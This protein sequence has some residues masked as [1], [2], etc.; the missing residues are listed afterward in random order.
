MELTCAGS[1]FTAVTLEGT[2][3]L[4]FVSRGPSNEVRRNPEP[5]FG[6]TELLPIAA[7]AGLVDTVAAPLWLL[8]TAVLDLGRP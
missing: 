7:A 2:L 4:S 5:V 3:D 8:D 1:L 6:S